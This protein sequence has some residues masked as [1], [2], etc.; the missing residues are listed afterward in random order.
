MSS[1]N[2]G[3]VNINDMNDWL[4]NQEDPSQFAVTALTE[5]SNSLVMMEAEVANVE[6]GWANGASGQ[7]KYLD[8][9]LNAAVS[10]MSAPGV[11]GTDL[12][13]AQAKF[14]ALQT[15]VSNSEQNYGNVVQ[16]GTTTLNA[17]QTAQQQFNSLANTPIQQKGYV[18]NLIM[19]WS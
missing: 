11:S 19:A 15:S 6:Q 16:G 4:N 13:K 3:S 10:A 9:Q 5:G 7:T 8:D 18:N 2:N 12:Q 14:Q 17:T 1:N